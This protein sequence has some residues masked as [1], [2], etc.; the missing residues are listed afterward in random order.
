MVTK[1]TLTL[2]LIL[3]MPATAIEI[4]SWTDDRGVTHYSTHPAK[5]IDSGSFDHYR[6]APVR[7]SAQTAQEVAMRGGMDRGA[8]TATQGQERGV[9]STTL[10]D[11]LMERIRGNADRLNAQ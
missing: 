3:P 9:K 5:C 6:C 2:L 1:M 8:E 4:H 7:G 10:I 11:G